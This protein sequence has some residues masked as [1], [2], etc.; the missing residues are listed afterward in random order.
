[1]NR[2]T[3]SF[4]HRRPLVKLTF[5]AAVVALATLE[6]HAQRQSAAS[7]FQK[8]SF[9]ATKPCATPATGEITSLVKNGV[10]LSVSEDWDCDGIADAYDNCVGMP[11]PEQTDGDNNRVGDV[12][13]AATTVTMGVVPVKTRT[14]AKAK[15]PM[16][17]AG[18]RHSRSKVS[19]DV[20]QKQAKR[21]RPR[22]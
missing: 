4:L 7:P 2:F 20:R 18:G 11:N 12:C 22:R 10:E 3:N 17:K 21:R 1:M 15:T 16:A 13:E 9:N 19:R 6:A 8:I 5:I 14:N